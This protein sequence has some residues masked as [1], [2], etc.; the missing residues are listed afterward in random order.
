MSRPVIF[1]AP[2]ADDETLNMGITIAEHMAA[3]RETHV[4][5]MTHG[6]V[7][8]ALNAINGVTYSGYW[9]AYHVPDKE[10]YEPLTQGILAQARIEEFWNACGQLGVPES[11]RHIEYLDD[12]NGDGGET[13]TVSEAKQVMERYASIYPE[14]DHYTMSY[15]DVHPD[16]AACGTA[17][18]RL[19]DE[20]KIL[21]YARFLISMA[22]RMDYESRNA[23]IPGGG[24][25]DS[26]TDS[27]ITTQ[28]RNACRCYSAWAP[29]VGAYAIGYHSVES[30]F[31]KLLENP[32]HYLH[33]P[34]E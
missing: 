21:Y 8:G 24:W 27:M 10:G 22:T 19:I 6:R 12:P 15:H 30:Q 16:H 1:Y 9:D 25:K 33:K 7:T 32:F 14:A 17:L 4:V 11:N 18:Q 26:P 20:G 5:L 29:S 34:G 31:E 3:G 13:I 23:T 28:I 2:H